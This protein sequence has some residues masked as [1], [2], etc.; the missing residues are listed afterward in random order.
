MDERRLKGV[1]AAPGAALGPIRLYRSE[2]PEGAPE[3][4]RGTPAEEM[5]RFEEA[6]RRVEA[7]LDGLMARADPQGREILEAHRMM[8]Q[9]PQLRAAVE[10]AVADG[11]SAA[12]AVGRAVEQFAAL[13]A[14]LD[15]EYLRERAA[16][17]RDVG[18]RLAAAL[19]GATVGL[20]LEQPAVVV[21]RDLAPSDTLGIDRSLLLGI[22]TEQGGPTSHTAILA[23]SRGIPAVVGTPGL[24]AAARE[25]ALIALDGATGDVIIAPAAPTRAAYETRVAAARAEAERERADSGLPAE[26][27]DGR[28]IELAGNAGSSDEVLFAVQKGAEGIG[29]LRSEFLF[30]GRAEAPDEEEQCRAYAAALQN[31]RGRRVIIR[32]LDIGGDKEIPYL[33]IPL[34]ENPFLGVRALRLCFR[35]PDLF[36]TQLR[37]LLRASVHGR[38]AVMFPMVSGLGELRKARAELDAVRAELAGDARPLAEVEVGIMVEIPSAAL[39]APH[40][41]AEVDFFSV[42]T[43]DL[44]QYTLA[45]DRGN[46][47]LAGLYQ[48]CHP[49]VLQLIDRVVRAAHDRGK[50]VGVCGEAAGQPEAALLLLGLGVDELSM[51]PA[52]LARIRRLVRGVPY[53]RAQALARQALEMATAEEVLALIRPELGRGE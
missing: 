12:T 7:D 46:P 21:A 38:L 11:A 37:A 48:P 14:C 28:R 51:A 43:N 31:A 45:V 26:T 49:A 23:R 24:L 52:S 16:D 40:L 42:G 13:L 15:D 5:A 39:L 17:V 30:M 25:G 4:P 8:L 19:R 27:P 53:A 35:R 29:L 20:R 3:P 36:R 34:E 50:W 9:D 47:E 2:P 18:R 1:P 32:T 22:A 44:V 33:G 41:A 10:E 6:L